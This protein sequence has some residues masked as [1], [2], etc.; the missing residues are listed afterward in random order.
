[1]ITVSRIR[2][3][4]IVPFEIDDDNLKKLFSY[5]LHRAPSIQSVSALEASVDDFGSMWNKFIA[6]WD[7]Q[8]LPYRIYS[9]KSEFPKES[10][11]KYK[12]GLSDD[13]HIH[14]KSR[15]F[16]CF[17]KDTTEHKL[18]TLLR[19][20]RNSIAHGRVFMLPQGNRKYILFEDFSLRGKKRAMILFSQSDL[21]ELRKATSK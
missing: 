8:K 10:V 20:L 14:K 13:S 17:K 19:H 6:K 5:F 21:Q 1:M 15:A 16:I 2:E 9:E 3:N 18:E 11:V 7:E 12:Y 4:C